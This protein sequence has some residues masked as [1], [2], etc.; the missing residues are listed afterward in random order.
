[1]TSNPG[2]PYEGGRGYR[3][4]SVEGRKKGRRIYE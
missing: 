4:L 2:V 1:M 3:F